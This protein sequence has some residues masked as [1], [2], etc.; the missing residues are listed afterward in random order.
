M[1]LNHAR[2]GAGG[3]PRVVDNPPIARRNGR[4]PRV[5]RGFS[6][7]DR[8]NRAVRPVEKFQGFLVIFR[9]LLAV[10]AACLGAGPGRARQAEAADPA[11][12]AAPAFA[13]EIE[14]LADQFGVGD[15]V[16]PGEWAGIRLRLTDRHDRP[17]PVSIRIN[18]PDP[19]GDTLSVQR[20]VTLNPGA[21]QSVWMYLPLPW[22]AGVGA[23]F[24]VTAVDLSEAGAGAD[25]DSRGS[26]AGLAA[27]GRLLGQASI[28]VKRAVR[29]G[30]S[31]IGVL[32]RGPAANLV[33]Y[34]ITASQPPIPL[35]ANEL[36]QVITDL[37]PGA[38]PDRW[39]GLAQYESIVWLSGDPGELTDRQAQALREWVQRGGRLYIALP[40]VG[41]QWTAARSNPI[42]DMLPLVSIRREERADLEPFRLLLAPRDTSSFPRRSAVHFMTPLETAQPWEATPVF[43][44]RDGGTVA[45]QRVVGVGA[46]TL[47]GFDLADSQLGARI[48]AGVF[49]HRLL[50]KRF[51]VRTREELAEAETKRGVN[52]LRGDPRYLDAVIAG[53]ITR[54]GKAAVG[55]LLGLAVFALY[56]VLAGPLGFRLLRWR[57][58]EKRAWPVFAVLAGVFTLVAW[59]GATVSR[60]L[61]PDVRHITFL[62]HVYGQPL[63]HARVWLGALLPTYGEATVSVGDPDDRSAADR[64]DAL[65]PWERP[66]S[67]FTARFPDARAYRMAGASP[68]SLTFP[69]R[70][71][72]KELRADWLGGPAW[73]MPQ[74]EGGPVRLV[75]TADSTRLEGVLT[76]GMPG[77]LK[78]VKV[79]LVRGQTPLRPSRSDGGPSLS[80]VSAWSL[81]APWNPG[82][83]LN[84]AE[85]YKQPSSLGDAYFGRLASTFANLPL[86][87]INASSSAAPSIP[88]S[89]APTAYEALGFF[90]SLAQPDYLSK[91]GTVLTQVQRRDA[92][93]LDLSPWLAAPCV[94]IVGRIDDGPCPAPILVNGERPAASGRTMVRWVHPLDGRPPEYMS[95]PR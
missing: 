7:P 40:S 42:Y 18:R 75:S 44:G 72:V 51:D 65:A 54:T 31:L 84:L 66:D 19:D 34:S 46:V 41:Q 20:D 79:L 27:S 21:A 16:R 59:G 89:Q 10:A 56:L 83:A 29:A 60:P 85:V 82:E 90:A 4:R 12:P 43:R 77:P 67:L 22:T 63:Q 38:L 71:T 53:E 24:T 25:P 11:K 57:N 3:K 2:A 28:A 49:W 9:V 69:T 23:A 26:A 17:R 48:D 55:V 15:A 64:H 52:K 30:D 50:G 87:G 86:S 5:V 6:A 68:S 94:I 80:S 74:P 1:P 45:A 95:P 61:R 91:P 70:S 36:T 8:Y 88:T 92:H 78:D 13:G 32:G 37:S 35:T 14:I 76:H 81:S 33:D 73:K 47:I 62:D 39:M 93:G 58:A